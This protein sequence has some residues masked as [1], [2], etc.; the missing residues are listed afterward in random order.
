M[1]VEDYSSTA[2]SREQHGIATRYGE[3]LHLRWPGAKL[4]SVTKRDPPSV[5]MIEEKQL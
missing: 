5:G 3:H 1:T 2:L 4:L